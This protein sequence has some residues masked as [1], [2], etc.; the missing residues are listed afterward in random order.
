MSGIL[1]IVAGLIAAAVALAVLAY[2]FLLADRWEP[3]DEADLEETLAPRAH[4]RIVHP[5]DP[6]E[7]YDRRRPRHD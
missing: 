1:L 3:I 5:R 2:Y 6:G 7:S 4:I